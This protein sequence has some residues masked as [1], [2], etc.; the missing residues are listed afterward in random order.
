M[1]ADIT[2]PISELS[3]IRSLPGARVLPSVLRVPTTSD[4]DQMRTAFLVRTRPGPSVVPDVTGLELSDLLAASSDL[5]AQ[6]AREEKRLSRGTCDPDSPEEKLLA[7]VEGLEAS[8]EQKRQLVSGIPACQALALARH[9]RRCER[10]EKVTRELMNE[11]KGRSEVLFAARRVAL[12]P[13]MDVEAA[14]RLARTDL[15][16]AVNAV[17]EYLRSLVIQLRQ[18]K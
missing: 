12:P 9:R 16:K 1:A 15:P 18:R 10:C 5:D 7:E 13:D 3:C 11:L 8:V 14:L 6:I 17:Q 2:V 4:L